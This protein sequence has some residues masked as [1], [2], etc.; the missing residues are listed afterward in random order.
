[1]SELSLRAAK[2]G[3]TDNTMISHY[4][5][6][7]LHAPAFADIAMKWQ[8]LALRSE[9]NCFLQWP[10]IGRWLTTFKPSR[11]HLVEAKFGADIVGLAILV[12]HIE[13]RHG[14]F[15]AKQLC[16]H[17][18]GIA[19]NDEIW[20]EYNDFLLD[21]DHAPALRSQMFRYICDNLVFD[22]LVFGVADS[23]LIANLPEIGQL[24]REDIWQANAYCVRFHD[25]ATAPFDGYLS[26]NSRYQ[27]KRSLKLYPEY[28]FQVACDQEQAADW[29][30]D[31]A[32][33]HQ[34]RWPQSGFRLA[35]FTEFHQQMIEH[36]I[37]D[38]SVQ[39]IKITLDATTRVYL[40]NFISAGKVY[41]YLSAIAEPAGL[42]A[43][44]N[45]AKPGLVA[46]YLAIDFYKKQG[47]VAYDFMGGEARYK[48]S[49]ANEITELC[50]TRFQR[51]LPLLRIEHWLKQLKTQWYKWRQKNKSDSSQM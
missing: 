22:E 24:R 8:A 2:D 5:F 30:P 47:F 45:K 6:A 46:H 7:T 10:W 40:Y 15:R 12:E 13:W 29:L 51:P 35:G 50:I 37:A 44:S 33:L 26:A 1:M 17:R 36:G 4:H 34:L 41:F 20:I 3:D 39:L 14:C 31:I 11:Y 49:F 48:A 25:E 32:R 9:P 43:G 21:S 28:Q 18:T 19:T 27:I 16:L 23:R 38:G 42:T